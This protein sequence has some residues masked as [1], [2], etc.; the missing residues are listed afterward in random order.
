MSDGTIALQAMANNKYVC[1][2]LNNGSVLYA[3]RDSIGG[4]WETFTLTSVP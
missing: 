3:N 2:D 1:A 4:A